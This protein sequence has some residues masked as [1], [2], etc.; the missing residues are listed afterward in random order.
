MSGDHLARDVCTMWSRQVPQS[1]VHHCK[2]VLAQVLLA[3]QL[4]H[5]FLTTI[6][7]VLT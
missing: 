6:S 5:C 2:E 4:S 3:V 7:F 1:L